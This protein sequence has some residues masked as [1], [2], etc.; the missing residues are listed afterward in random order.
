METMG[1][2]PPPPPHH[3]SAMQRS[4]A[5]LHPHSLFGMVTDEQCDMPSLTTPAPTPDQD[6]DKQGLC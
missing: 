3:D 5:Q 1:G 6:T 2:H 4:Q